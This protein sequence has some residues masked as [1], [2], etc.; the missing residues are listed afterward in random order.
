MMALNNYPQSIVQYLISFTTSLDTIRSIVLIASGLITIY[1]AYRVVRR[2]INIDISRTVLREN[3]VFI[4]RS[5][6]FIDAFELISTGIRL[7]Q[8]NGYSG[9][10][11]SYFLE[12]FTEL[13]NGKISKKIIRQKGLKPLVK[14]TRKYRAFYIDAGTT[15]EFSVTMTKVLRKFFEMDK[16]DDAEHFAMIINNFYK[17]QNIMLIIDNVNSR[18]LHSDLNH[19]ITNYF[20]VRPKDMIF[21]GTNIDYSYN[22]KKGNIK[23]TRFGDGEILEFYKA[24]N[25]EVPSDTKIIE[26]RT[27]GLPVFLSVYCRNNESDD[28]ESIEETISSLLKAS[29]YKEKHLFIV[30]LLVSL[31]ETT[32]SYETLTRLPISDL[33]LDATLEK[34]IAKFLVIDN[35]KLYKVHDQISSILFNEVVLNNDYRELT[36]KTL[37][38]LIQYYQ[39]FSSD[40][41]KLN[42]IFLQILLPV[43]QKVESAFT[44]EEIINELKCQVAEEQ[45]TFLLVIGKYIFNDICDTQFSYLL[46]NSHFTKELYKL[47]ILTLQYVGHYNDAL[48]ELEKYKMKYKTYRIDQIETNSD[49]E[50]YY[51]E[52]D[53]FHMHTNFSEAI[54][55]FTLLL[56][57]AK[58]KNFTEFYVKTIYQIA[59]NERHR[60]RNLKIAEEWYERATQEALVHNNF[61][62]YIRGLVGV[63]SVNI[64]MYN[65]AFD[66][67]SYF[68]KMMQQIENLPE[69]S[70]IRAYVYKYYARYK[71]RINEFDCAKQFYLNADKIYKNNHSRKR[72]YLLFDWAEY[73][74][75]KGDNEKALYYYRECVTFAENSNEGNFVIYSM[76]G[77]LLLTYKDIGKL[78]TIKKC[79]ELIR[80]ANRV[81]NDI[82]KLQIEL[83]RKSFVGHNNDELKSLIEY[84][85][86]FSLN[87]EVMLISKMKQGAFLPNELLLNLA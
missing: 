48:S 17:N 54:S 67:Q 59:H 18:P 83:L 4:D 61:E 41:C 8:V 9:I 27:M 21:I 36:N 37:T 29:T 57:I 76:L 84:Y 73:Y 72:N 75:A 11:K 62:F 23:L 40:E 80:R 22:E 58:K 30:I 49:F 6:A 42:R 46:R 51:M 50:L 74:R 39:S 81:S 2:R 25:H 85:N 34:L 44:H 87:S 28:S 24:Y 77:E 13:V 69:N 60:G 79:D 26:K 47:Y 12:F 38:E 45:Y 14:K 43:E 56:D 65:L 68:N 66:F 78:E 82:V 7:I 55:Q 52:A 35:E 5:K 32:I 1:G 86:I 70:S 33:D 63:V 3:E 64:M 31:L 71:L 20:K 19:F 15:D 16:Y 53:T 10:G